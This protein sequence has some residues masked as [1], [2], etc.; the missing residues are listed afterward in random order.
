MQMLEKD[1]QLTGTTVE[2]QQA[3]KTVGLLQ[4]QL[5]TSQSVTHHTPRLLVKPKGRHRPRLRARALR[6]GRRAFCFSVAAAKSFV[7]EVESS[8]QMR[9]ADM[10]VRAEQKETIFEPPCLHWSAQG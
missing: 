2:L 10:Q 5:G 7:E 8:K 9:E 1:Y 6:A 3:K 4:W